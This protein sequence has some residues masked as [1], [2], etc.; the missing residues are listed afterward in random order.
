MNEVIKPI[1]ENTTPFS[2]ST[3]TTTE[4]GNTVSYPRVMVNDGGSII[5]VLFNPSK[6]SVKD[7]FTLRKVLFSNDSFESLLKMYGLNKLFNR[8]I[9]KN[10]TITIRC[11]NSYEIFSNN[12][13]GIYY[14]SLN[15][16]LK[17]E[18]PSG[19]VSMSWSD[20]LHELTTPD[21]GSDYSK[22]S[23]GLDSIISKFNQLSITSIESP[24]H[25]SS[26]ILPSHHISDYIS[27]ENLLDSSG[28]RV[29]NEGDVL[30][31]T[32][33]YY[34]IPESDKLV[35]YDLNQT[36]YDSSIIKFSASLKGILTQTFT[37]VVGNC[38]SELDTNGIPYL[39]KLN[40][41]MI[42]EVSSDRLII[43]STK[44]NIKEYVIKSCRKL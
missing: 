28:N 19:L 18:S 31:V 13:I 34:I 12:S 23:E 16:R 30:E 35:K 2:I 10:G 33:G 42:A 36:Y 26:E 9:L 32:I 1:L 7:F 37:C 11:L 6:S 25:Q 17:Y 43:Y 24:S 4:N 8:Y 15:N 29:I 5:D 39:Y 38:E 27:F 20:G 14:G 41:G 21:Y 22:L 40:N 3:L 44:D